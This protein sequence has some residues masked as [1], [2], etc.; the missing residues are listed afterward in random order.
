[1]YSRTTALV[2]VLSM[3]AAGS[4][5]SVEAQAGGAASA[6]MK[7]N[8]NTQV[9]NVQHHGGK[10]SQVEITQFTSSSAKGSTSHH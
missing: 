7:T 4:L 10:G 8:H 2:A 1:M 3:I 6:A 5:F 9:A